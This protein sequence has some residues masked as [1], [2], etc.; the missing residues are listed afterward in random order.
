[1]LEEAMGVGGGGGDGS[2]RENELL[3]GVPHGQVDGA[4]GDDLHPAVASLVV[5]PARLQ[6]EDHHIGRHGSEVGQ[7]LKRSLLSRL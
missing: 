3:E 7:H 5:H 6:V 1:M 4:D 2:S